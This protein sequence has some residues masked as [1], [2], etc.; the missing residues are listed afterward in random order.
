[1]L[2]HYIEKATYYWKKSDTV[3]LKQYINIVC[4]NDKLCRIVTPTGDQIKYWEEMT[5]SSSLRLID[6]HIMESN[7]HL[8]TP[9]VIAFYLPTN[10]SPSFLFIC[11]NFLKSFTLLQSKIRKF[12]VWT[13]SH[14]LCVKKVLIVE[15]C[16]KT[17]KII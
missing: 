10:S 14:T 11:N 5:N 4:K 15:L 3:N 2:F 13:A 6:I 1:M 16:Q 7:A 17:L 9:I 8:Q 12:R